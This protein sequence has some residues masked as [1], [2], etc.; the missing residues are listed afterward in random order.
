MYFIKRNVYICYLLWYQYNCNLLLLT[1]LKF[2]KSIVENLY[3][4]WFFLIQEAFTLWRNTCLKVNSRSRIKSVSVLRFLVLT[5][6][7]SFRVSRSCYMFKLNK[8]ILM[9]CICLKLRQ[10]QL[11]MCLSQQLSFICSKSIT[12][13]LEQCVKT[14]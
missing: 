5:L 4:I 3:W 8:E 2:A 11:F 12:E 10:L 13:T 6:S 9:C 14:V 1:S 7:S